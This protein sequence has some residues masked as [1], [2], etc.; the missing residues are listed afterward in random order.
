MML[1]VPRL[2]EMVFRRPVRDARCLWAEWIEDEQ[3][4]DD[5]YAVPFEDGKAGLRRRDDPFW[6]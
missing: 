5:P 1:G 3:T 2:G 6:A 4:E